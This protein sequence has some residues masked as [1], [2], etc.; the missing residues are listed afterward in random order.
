MITHPFTLFRHIIKS[1]FKNQQFVNN[2]TLYIFANFH[3]HNGTNSIKSRNTAMA[4][5]LI[6]RIRS[7]MTKNT[8]LPF[9]K[10]S[11]AARLF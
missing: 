11:H 3:T 8:T 4:K 9:I 1:T 10:S 6:S 2:L 7:M 5:P